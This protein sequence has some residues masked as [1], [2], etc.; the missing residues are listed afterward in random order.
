MATM[1]RKASATVLSLGLC[2]SLGRPPLWAAPQEPRPR[3]PYSVKMNSQDAA[4]A[5][6]VLA[7]LDG[8][9]R[10]YPRLFEPAALRGVEFVDPSGGLERESL[11]FFR[12]ATKELILNPSQ[13]FKSKG[14][15]GLYK[16]GLEPE[17][18]LFHELL[19]ALAQSLTPAGQKASRLE[20]D[21][22]EETSDKRRTA[23]IAAWKPAQ[24]QLAERMRKILDARLRATPRDEIEKSY[25]DGPQSTPEER[26]RMAEMRRS[27]LERYDRIAS[28]MSLEQA[29]EILVA[30]NEERGRVT[31][32]E[33]ESLAIPAAG[34]TPQQLEE[35]I[36]AVREREPQRY[37][38]AMESLRPWKEAN[39]VGGQVAKDLR[40]NTRL[41]LAQHRIP[42]RDENDVHATEGAAEWFAYGGEFAFY[43]EDPSLYLTAK[44]Q[45]FWRSFEPELRGQREK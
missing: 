19:H 21:Y 14:R 28:Q 2:L 15:P 23:F 41:L 10:R 22:A 25:P 36:S 31:L 43:A 33:A 27:A 44:E 38:A 40:E 42:R 11:L 12:L 9:A 24:R 17:S 7:I 6:R 26:A 13:V 45:A 3:R 39:T 20:L 1:S 34:K 18:I 37:Q 29:Q 35:E 4:G 32:K 16:N 30:D 8:L 5:G